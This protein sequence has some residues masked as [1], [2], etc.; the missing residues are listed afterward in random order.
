MVGNWATDAASAGGSFF[1]FLFA[2]SF[3]APDP[4]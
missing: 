4:L 3:A 1:P 2:R